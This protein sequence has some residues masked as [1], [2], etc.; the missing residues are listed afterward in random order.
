MRRFSDIPSKIDNKRDQQ[1][2]QLNVKLAKVRPDES[3][4]EPAASGSEQQWKETGNLGWPSVSSPP[5]C[6]NKTECLTKPT[7]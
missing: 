6:G 4:N 7:Y 5:L 3:K 2:M 1:K